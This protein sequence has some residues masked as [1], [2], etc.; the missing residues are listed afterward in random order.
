VHATTVSY[1][2]VGQNI[3]KTMRLFAAGCKKTLLSCRQV[4]IGMPRFVIVA[5][6]P[7]IASTVPESLLSVLDKRRTIAGPGFNRWLV[8]PAALCV[9]LCIGMAYG[10][11]VF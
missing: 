10:F 7:A 9:H 3:G 2:A 8:P 4:A 1:R 6:G 11:S 5:G